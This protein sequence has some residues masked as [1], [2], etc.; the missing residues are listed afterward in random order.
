M[1]T[2]KVTTIQDTA[3]ANSSTT[4]EIKNGIAVPG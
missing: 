4:A 2:L 3:G 1:S